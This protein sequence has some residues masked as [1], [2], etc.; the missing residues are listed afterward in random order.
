MLVQCA[1]KHVTPPG[2]ACPC[3]CAAV[4][5]RLSINAISTR[6]DDD[7]YKVFWGGEAWAPWSD[8]LAQ[9]SLCAGWAAQTAAWHRRCRSVTVCARAAHAFAD[10][11]SVLLCCPSHATHMHR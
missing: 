9:K 2:R 11:A 8:A 3:A 4:Q 5:P 7:I 1:S 6:E 10:P